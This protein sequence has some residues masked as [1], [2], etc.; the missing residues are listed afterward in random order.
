MSYR[1][2]TMDE[3]N[4]IWRMRLLGHSQ[5]G[6]ARCLGRHP[7]TVGRERKRN[8]QFDGRYVPD[9]AQ[10]KADGRR[11]VHIRRPKT[12]NAAL[13]AHVGER[14]GRRSKSPGDWGRSARPSCRA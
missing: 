1:H 9:V 13:M 12:G 11:R 6:I 14:L 2:L 8:A 3:R 7:S 4:V 5:A 10:A